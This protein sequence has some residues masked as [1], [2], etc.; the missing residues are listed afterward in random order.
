MHQVE[1]FAIERELT[2]IIPL[3]R[4]G[5]LVAQSPTLY[6][7]ID[8]AEA[9]NP[10]E[11]AHLRDEV[12]HKWRQPVALYF[13][14]ITCS[15][16]AAVQGWDQTGSVSPQGDAMSSSPPLTNTRMEQTCRFLPCLELGANQTTIL[17]L[18]DWSIRLPTSRAHS[19]AAG[20][21][22]R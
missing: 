21:A 5:A 3:L 7:D 16:G 6:E 19:S 15:V 1:K 20:S 17:S 2:D 13:T 14:I 10:D 4:K 18:W 11:I 12:L 8:G 22:T 9:L